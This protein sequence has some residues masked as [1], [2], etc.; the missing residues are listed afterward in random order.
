V[1]RPHEYVISTMDAWTARR[2]TARAEMTAATM[3]HLREHGK[4]LRH[5]DDTPDLI[6]IAV[7]PGDGDKAANIIRA[8][9]D[10]EQRT[11]RPMTPNPGKVQ[12]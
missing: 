5:T 7:C 1:N 9:L 4:T 10:S 11:P 3:R 6:V 8:A 12:S 2:P